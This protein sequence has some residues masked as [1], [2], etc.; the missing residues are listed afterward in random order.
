M[1]S[2]RPQVRRQGQPHVLQYHNVNV[3][4]RRQEEDSLARRGGTNFGIRYVLFRLGCVVTAPVALPQS[5]HKFFPLVGGVVRGPGVFQHR[6]VSS[7]GR[8]RRKLAPQWLDSASYLVRPTSVI[9]RLICL[10][11][12]RRCCKTW[13]ARRSSSASRHGTSCERGPSVVVLRR[14]PLK[15][16]NALFFQLTCFGGEGWTYRHK[17]GL[18]PFTVE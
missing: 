8:S 10:T 5:C 14:L 1:E 16:R 13:S 6:H 15:Y 2:Q 3:D 11:I 7:I 4:T 17:F 9:V 12:C 18:G